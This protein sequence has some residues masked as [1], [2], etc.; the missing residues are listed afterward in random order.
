VLR[1]NPIPKRRAH[2]NGQQPMD[3]GRGR[4]QMEAGGDG[5]AA[6]RYQRDLQAMKELGERAENVLSQ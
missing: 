2:M 5:D 4:G 6:A 3:K 1:R